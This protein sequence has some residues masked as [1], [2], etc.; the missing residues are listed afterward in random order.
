M[1]KL[2]LVLSLFTSTMLLTAAIV[3]IGHTDVHTTLAGVAAFQGLFFGLT[4]FGIINI[5]QGAL[6]AYVGAPGAGSGGVQ[7]ISSDKTR[8][9]Y[10]VYAT[11]PEYEGKTIFES[12]LRLETKLING[13][14]SVKF[15]TYA[16][17][18]ASV[19][20]TERRLDRNDK[21]AIT[22]LG[23]FLLKQP[24][25]K[26][27]GQLHPYPNL[28]DFSTLGLSADL[29][30]IYHGK[31]N[32]TIGGKRI[33]NGLDM[34]RFRKVPQTQQSAATNYDMSD[35]YRKLTPITPNLNIDGSANNEIE[36]I[37]PSHAAWAGGTAPAGFTH[38]LVMYAHG[39]LITQG[40]GNI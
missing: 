26:S 25:N 16:G 27:N 5:P 33:V 13:V 36:V 10:M 1:K 15:L 2:G 6:G 29:E 38:Y 28:T 21:F 11:N 22:K 37:Y 9:A 8:G 24:D 19:L 4:Q 17:D 30:S 7:V 35:L 31:L 3:T 23:F 39:F 20:P 14:N 18:S 12:F 32:I 34:Q 40:S